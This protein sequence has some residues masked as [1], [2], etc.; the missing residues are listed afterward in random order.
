MWF[1]LYSRERF[2]FV[3]TSTCKLSF[4]HENNVLICS[5]YLYLSQ[6]CTQMAWFPPPLLFLVCVCVCVWGGGCW[7]LLYI[8]KWALLHCLQIIMFLNLRSYIDGMN[9]LIAPKQRQVFSLF[10]AV[11]VI[12][13]VRLLKGLLVFI[14]CIV[15][16][17]NYLY[18][19]MCLKYIRLQVFCIHNLSY[20]CQRMFAVF[21][22][23]EIQY[24]IIS[25]KTV[26][27]QRNV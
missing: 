1:L 2:P 21:R 7:K 14:W 27:I 20:L 5:C 12:D 23:M 13:T 19:Q 11:S 22:E 9:F 4:V 16:V 17:I 26:S 8:C 10:L 3:N 25:L 15:I 18:Q 6:N 24:A